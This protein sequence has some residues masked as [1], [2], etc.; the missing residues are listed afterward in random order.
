M[1]IMMIIIPVIV[2]IEKAP[3]VEYNLSI[4]VRGLLNIPNNNDKNNA[5]D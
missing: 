1:I 3:L 2:R 5:H 4:P